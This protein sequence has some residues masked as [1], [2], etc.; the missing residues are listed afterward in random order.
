[1]SMVIAKQ[2]RNLDGFVCKQ[3]SCAQSDVSGS[4]DIT[5]LTCISIVQLVT[6][7]RHPSLSLALCIF[8]CF[9]NVLALCASYKVCNFFLY[10]ESVNVSWPILLPYGNHKL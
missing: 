5:I 6:G 8:C 7:Y 2:A 4:G 9:T 1:M 3:P 10:T